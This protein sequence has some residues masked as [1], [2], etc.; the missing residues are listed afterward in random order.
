M[1]MG[2]SLGDMRTLFRLVGWTRRPN[3]CFV[4]RNVVAEGR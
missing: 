4:E 3:S 2:D 1:A